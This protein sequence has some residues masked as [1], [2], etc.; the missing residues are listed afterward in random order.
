MKCNLLLLLLGLCFA[1]L[2]AQSP[3]D[4][5]QIPDHIVIGTLENIFKPVQ[6]D[7]KLHADMTVMGDGCTTCHHH[8]EEDVFEPCAD[9]H[10]TEED[11]ASLEMPTLNGA[12]HRSCLNCHQ[13]WT[14]DHVCETCHEKQKLR[15]NTRKALD[16]TDILAHPHKEIIVPKMFKFVTPGSKQKQVVFHHQEHVDLYRYKC[17]HCHRQT[18]CAS[19]HNYKPASADKIMTL[20]IHHNPC[21]NC[22]DTTTESNCSHCH[23]DKASSGFSH[24]M[25]GWKLN[26]FHQPLTC[27]SC[28]QGSEPVE[29]L[30]PSCIGCHDNFEVGSFDH[31]VTGL[32]LNEE[33]E[34]I[35]CYECHSDDRYDLTPSCNECHDEDISF[36]A[37]I[38]GTRSGK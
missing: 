6:F 24:E 35:D 36:P 9:C 19:C 16:A 10:M 34:E 18:N 21:S 15:F 38:P 31:A 23:L 29:A 30:D 1:T 17:E 7:H 26:R 32:V 13:D 20:D 5:S 28:H 11:N 27:E 37:N 12:Y 4:H 3:A 8:G 14:G 2:P 25:T 22:H 33:H